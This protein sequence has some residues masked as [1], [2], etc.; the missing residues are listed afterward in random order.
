MRAL[1]ADVLAQIEKCDVPGKLPD[2]DIFEKVVLNCASYFSFLS[3]PPSEKYFDFHMD[4]SPGLPWI[5][6]GC[7]KKRDVLESHKELLFSFYRD[8]S[9]PVVDYYADKDEFLEDVDLA[10]HK[11]RGIFSSGFHGLMREK[12][13]YGYQNKALLENWRN[14]WIKYGMIKQYGG[15]DQCIRKLEKFTFRWESD[16]SGWDR[17]VCFD[18]V[19][20]IRNSLIQGAENWKELIEIVTRSNCRSI[21]L[22]P[23]GHIIERQTGNDSGKNNTTT[24]NCLAHFLILVYLFYKRLYEI[25]KPEEC[26]LSFLFNNVCLNI[27]S[28][29]KIG[30]F[31]LETFGFG[32]PEEFISYECSVYDEFGMVLKPAACLWTLARSGDRIDPRHSFLGSFCHFDEEFAKYVPYPRFGKLCSGIVQ[33]ITIRDPLIRFARAVNLALNAFPDK[34]LFEI[35]KKYLYFIYLK[36]PKMRYRYDEILDEFSIDARLTTSFQTIYLGF[37]S[38]RRCQTEGLSSPPSGRC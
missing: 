16:T 7:K 3:A 37:E 9:I 2:N 13:L 34:M 5:K 35:F 14:C 29:D 36:E 1:R 18:A 30:S 20:R 26:K 38:L 32:T 19:Y 31:D 21:V 6:M 23:D 24:D 12:F 33:K 25:G 4:T 15:F 17:T 28:D 22:L 11:I 8:L 27:Y 10:R